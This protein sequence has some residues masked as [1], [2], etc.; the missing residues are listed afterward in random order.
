MNLKPQVRCPNCR[1]VREG[2]DI[3][4]RKPF[5]CRRCGGNFRVARWCVRAAS[6]AG[7][8]ICA[9]LFYGFGVRNGSV[10]SGGWAARH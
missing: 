9:G 6:L 4:A 1:A 7:L 10:V 3:K 2:T 5:S 8:G